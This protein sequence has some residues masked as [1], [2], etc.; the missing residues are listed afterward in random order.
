MTTVINYSH[1]TIG[2]QGSFNILRDKH[3]RQNMEL[4]T[5]NGMNQHTKIGNNVNACN[6]DIPNHNQTRRGIIIKHKH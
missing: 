3:A 4:I 5:W 2:I 1:V 6:I